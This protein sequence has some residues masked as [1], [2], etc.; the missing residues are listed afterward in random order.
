MVQFHTTTLQCCIQY[1]TQILGYYTAHN[2]RYEQNKAQKISFG[3]LHHIICIS[4]NIGIKV[5]LDKKQV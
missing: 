3:V 2:T 1:H 5:Q 4:L